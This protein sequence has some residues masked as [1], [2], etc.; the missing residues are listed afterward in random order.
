MYKYLIINLKSNDTGVQKFLFFGGG[1]HS[2]EFSLDAFT[3]Q[4]SPQRKKESHAVHE[5][6]GSEF[7]SF[8][9]RVC[10]AM[11]NVDG[12]PAQRAK[13]LV[14]IAEEWYVF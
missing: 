4:A 12:Q 14:T 8:Y 9:Q 10:T 13:E 7:Y 3:F 6:F 5:E 11:H 2:C 1:A